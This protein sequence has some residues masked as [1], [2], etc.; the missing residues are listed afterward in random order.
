MAEIISKQ[1][2]LD[3]LIQDGFLFKGNWLCI[4]KTSLRKFL[5]IEHHASGLAA[6][7]G[8]GKTINSVEDRCF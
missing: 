6:H 1:P 4:P 5:M 3:Y 8:R 2:L 7:R